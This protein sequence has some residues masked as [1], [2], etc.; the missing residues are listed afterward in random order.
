MDSIKQLEVAEQV[1]AENK[2][3]DM[4]EKENLLTFSIVPK[5]TETDE[6]GYNRPT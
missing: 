6:S 2:G 5:T 4:A 1:S 3:D